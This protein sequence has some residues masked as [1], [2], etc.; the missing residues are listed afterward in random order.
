[1]TRTMHL[2]ETQIHFWV[3]Q[4]EKK[5]KDR[6]AREPLPA[7]AEFSRPVGHPAAEPASSR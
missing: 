3:L 5:R 1:M 4:E 2:V 7:R 6:G